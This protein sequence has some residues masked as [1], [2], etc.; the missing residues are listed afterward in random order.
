MRQ[1]GFTLIEMSIVLV[2]I[3]LIVGGIL[4][5]QELIDSARQKNVISQVDAIKAGVTTFVD[6]YKAY[7]GDF[8][9][10]S[11]V[12]S[13]LLTSGN[14]DGQ[15]GTPGTSTTDLLTLYDATLASENVQFW[16]HMLAAGTTGGGSVLTAGGT[17]ANFSGAGAASPLPSAAY[18]STGLSVV[19]GVHGGDT[20]VGGSS[21]EGH[22]LILHKWT[23]TSTLTTAMGAVNAAHGYAM[24]NKYDDGFAN[25][26]NI[27][28]TNAG[29]PCGT[30]STSYAP[31][32][33][34]AQ[35]CHM[36][37]SLE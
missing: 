4:K 18:P 28:T 20:N 16:E 29:S 30:N 32:S 26:G 15:I 2:I 22:F 17:V 10:A 24:D 35:V 33:A 7:P 9:R 12:I 19:Y 31:S 6:R 14:E 3:G 27:R 11:L 25:Q 34:T 23:G 36:V 8:A 5:G 21:R 37:F 13:T 1:R